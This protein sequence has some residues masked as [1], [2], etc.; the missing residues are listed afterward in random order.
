[1]SQLFEG[2]DIL[3][4]WVNEQPVFRQV[5]NMRP[6][7]QQIIYLFGASIRGCYLFDP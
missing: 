7:H 6:V 1:V 5:L 2:I 3:S 4:L